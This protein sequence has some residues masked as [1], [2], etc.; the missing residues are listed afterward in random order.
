MASRTGA[1]H[2]A[3]VTRKHGDKVYTSHL[4]RRTFRAGGKVK[5][6]TVGN[7]SHLPPHLV[8]MVRRALAGEQ[9]T[10]AGGLEVVRSRGHG[11]VALV[12]GVLRDLG[13]DRA[14]L[15]RACPERDTVVALLVSRLLFPGSKLASTRAWADTTLVEELGL[16]GVT[17]RGAYAAMDWLL[18]RQEA[19]QRALV[20]RHLPA[21]AV[22]LYDLSSS[23]FTGRHCPLATR[24][25]SRDH[26]GDLPQVN[27]GVV[28]DSEGRPVAVEVFAGNVKDST[29]VVEQVERLRKRHGLRRMVLVGDR[30]M[31][32]SVQVAALEK[33]PAVDWITALTN[34]QV[35]GLRDQ[36]TLQ[37]GLFDER[38]LVSMESPAFPGQRL[39]ACRNPALAAERER[40][41][42]ELLAA[43]ERRLETVR[44]AVES[45]RLRGAAAIAERLGRAW[46]NE[47]MRKHFVTE[48]GDDSLAYRRDEEAIAA[49][50]QL[51]GV[52][53][54]RTSIQ[55]A[56]A[57]PAAEV[58]RTYK[59]LSLVERVFRR[60]KTTELLV[61]PVFHRQPGRV[62]AHVFLCML[63]A[64]VA[65]ELERRLARFLYV[66]QGLAEA[67]PSRHPVRPPESSSEGAR[68]K[69][70]HVSADGFPLHDLPGL[71]RAMGSLAR[72][73]LRLAG[74]EATFDRDCEPTPWQRA[75]L[76][77]A[78]GDTG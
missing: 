66:D 55:D 78:L 53:V 71:L 8:D 42:R 4:L 26:R 75:V 76:E 60:M 23:Y 14:L 61:R 41:R 77:A 24:G 27:Y 6:E 65:V 63:A 48:V 22:V 30:G 32:T 40:K 54:I 28:T 56:P 1:V 69:R 25:Y 49:E 10:P 68:K 12:L 38:D 58:V 18:E 64:H 44:R 3:T 57:W 11:H 45:G 34:P 17:V 67:R 21:G 19:V 20:R 70:D 43:T 37:L 31:V 9:F 51:D 46:K 52:Y 39:V 47:R 16:E 33:Y 59:R 35:A 73:T 13:L 36:G 74:G 72:V 15:A 50:A 62:R 5:N 29:T 7:I 2:V